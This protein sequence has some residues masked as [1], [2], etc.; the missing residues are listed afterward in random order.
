MLIEFAAKEKGGWWKK[1]VLRQVANHMFELLGKDH[2]LYTN[3]HGL[4][5]Y[6]KGWIHSHTCKVYLHQFDLPK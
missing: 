6:P 4:W 5:N 1:H 2:P 3:D